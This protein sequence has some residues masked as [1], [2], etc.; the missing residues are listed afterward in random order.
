MNRKKEL[1]Y[2]VFANCFLSLEN[3]KLFLRNKLKNYS[4][5]SGERQTAINVEDIRKDHLG[6][7]QIV[8]NYIASVATSEKRVLDMFCGNGYGSFM[9]AESIPKVRILSVDGSKEAINLAK[10][11]YRNKNIV[12]KHKFFP[13]KLRNKYYDFIVSLESIEHVQDDNLFLDKIYNALKHNGVLFLSTPNEEK[14]SLKINPNHFHFRH[15]ITSEMIDLLEKKGFQLLKIYGQDVYV[16]N[17]E[18]KVTGLLEPEKMELIENYNGQ[19]CIYVLK[20][21]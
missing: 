20:K 21:I 8:V 14:Q 1:L 5:N 6:R 2:R 9:I 19:F 3:R 7:Y 16:I 17:H 10:K 12:Y 18:G 13:F 4:L 11:H 15:Y